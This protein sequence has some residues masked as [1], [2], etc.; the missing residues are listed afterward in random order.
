MKKLIP[1]LVLILLIMCACSQNVGR[2][3]IVSEADAV[4]LSSSDTSEEKEPLRDENGVLLSYST[5]L[6]QYPYMVGWITV[7]GTIID[8]PV[9]Q[10]DDNNY[11][12]TH[13]YKC[14]ESKNGAIYLDFLVD[15]TRDE[16]SRNVVI[17]GHHMKSGVMFANLTKYDD[18]EFLKSNPIVRFDSLYEENEWV[19]FA[20]MK[21]DAYGGENGMPTFNFMKSSFASD[22]D[23]AQ[24]I[25][26]IRARSVYDT[27][28]IVD[29][30]A[31]DSIIT[32]STCSYEYNDFRTVL[33]ARRLRP[34]ES[35]K[36]FD[37]S[38]LSFAKE[39]IMPPVWGEW[40][41]SLEQQTHY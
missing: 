18:I 1:V 13:D 10:C 29:V 7:P 33:V 32:M 30:N 17:H 19:I 40:T 34:D 38:S 39:C 14:E 21:I 2:Q 31:A 11:F 5:L 12:L 27:F 9:V 16:I 25:A 3:T 24:Y 36:S 35:E 6:S 28:D 23:F 15:F 22:E 37:F 20:M 4:T 41:G 26:D 8:Y